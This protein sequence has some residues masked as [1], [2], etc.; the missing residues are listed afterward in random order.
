MDSSWKVPNPA[1][2]T[3]TLTVLILASLCKS[4][5]SQ[6]P[7]FM[8]TSVSMPDS[9]SVQHGLCVHIPCQFTYDDSKRISSEKLYG[10]WFQKRDESLHSFAVLQQPYNGLGVLVA[11]NDYRQKVEA[12]F[13]NRFQLTGDPV[14]GNCSFSILNAQSQDTGKYYFLIADNNIFSNNVFLNYFTTRTQSHQTLQVL[15][16]EFSVKPEIVKSSAVIS[17]KEAVLTCSA[18]GPCSKI[19]PAVSWATVLTGYRTSLW[20]YQQSNGSWI[21]G[22]NFTFTPSPTDQGKSLTCQVW[23]PNIQKRVENIIF[24]DIS[25][26]FQEFSGSSVVLFLIVLCL[27]KVLFCFLLFFSVFGLAAGRNNK[28]QEG[29]CQC[30]KPDLLIRE[31]KRGCEAVNKTLPK[32]E[33]SEAKQ[34]RRYTGGSSLATGEIH[35]TIPIKQSILV[36]TNDK[37]QILMTSVENRFQLTGDPEQGNCSFS[38]LNARPQDSGKYYFRTEDSKI[39]YSYTT[40]KGR[41]RMMLE[42]LVTGLMSQKSDYTLTMPASVSVRQGLWVHIPCQFTYPNQTG[43]EELYGYWFKKKSH[44]YP[45]RSDPGRLVAT[46]DKKVA[47]DR[48]AVNRFQFTGDPNQ[49]MCSFRINDTQW[50]DEGEYYFRIEKGS[51][52]YTYANHSNQIHTSPSIFVFGPP[53]VIKILANGTSHG[54]AALC[55]QEAKRDVDSAVAQEG[56]RIALVCNVESRPDPTLSWRKGNK[57]LS[58]ARQSREHVLLLPKVRPEDAGEYLCWAKTPYGSARK[59]LQL[60]VQYGPRLSSTQQNSTCRREGNAILC[61][62][63]LHSWPPPQI[64]WQV[65]GKII[66]GSIPRETLQGKELTSSLNWTGSQKE[67]HSIVCSVTNP[68]GAYTLQFVLSSSITRAYPSILISALCGPLITAT[69]F[70]LGAYLICLL[71]ERKVS[72]DSNGQQAADDARSKGQQVADDTSDIYSNLMPREDITHNCVLQDPV[73]RYSGIYYNQQSIEGVTYSCVLPE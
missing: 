22:S 1:S 26:L 63:S 57:T 49:G 68:S 48:S 69:L 12:S 41:A 73:V 5:P 67:Y 55:S 28:L 23:Y 58:S 60:C 4:L 72:S 29:S 6:N 10:Y 32:F 14:Q 20:S 61:T 53:Q 54:H 11:T 56:E 70:L 43:S 64:K 17:G 19:E 16:T 50:G 59:T 27:I 30:G 34:Q 45:H 51:L 44:A 2:F 38:I 52:K 3:A 36:A 33:V 46:T 9:V 7:A 65:D 37:R 18:P 15:V 25:G 21:Y 39:I 62:C 66:N 31:R 47:V 71:K 13:A 40:A 35:N 42:V 24:L 8:L